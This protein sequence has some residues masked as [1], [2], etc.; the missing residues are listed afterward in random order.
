[1]HKIYFLIAASKMKGKT[2]KS[3]RKIDGEKMLKQ[4]QNQN[5]NETTNTH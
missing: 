1:M 2:A 5:E 4:T 3:N